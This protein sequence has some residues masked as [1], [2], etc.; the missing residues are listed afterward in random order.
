MS[1][2]DVA[3]DFPLERRRWSS[4][5]A[6]GSANDDEKRRKAEMFIRRVGPEGDVGVALIEATFHVEVPDRSSSPFL[7]C[8]VAA[9][10]HRLDRALQLLGKVLVLLQNLERR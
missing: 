6:S 3:L 5:V 9:F 8:L 10:H 4:P 2:L 1:G 7:S